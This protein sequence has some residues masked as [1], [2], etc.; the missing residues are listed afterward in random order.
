[1]EKQPNGWSEY[2]RLV[3][4]QLEEHGKRLTTIETM[5]VTI[6]VEMEGHKIR[7]GFWGGA[8]GALTGLLTVLTA[9]AIKLLS[10]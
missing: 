6:K 5:L 1:M 7:S 8:T 4:S 9:I 3:L 10:S 2:Q